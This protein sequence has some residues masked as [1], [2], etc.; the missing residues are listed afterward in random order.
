M[1]YITGTAANHT[2]LWNTLLDFLQNNPALVA[3]G[4]NWTIAWQHATRPN[5]ELVLKGPGTSGTDEVFVGLYRQDEANAIGES[6]IYI[7]GMTGVIPAAERY[8]DHVGVL[9]RRP[10]MFL[11]FSPM[12]YWMVAS[13][14]RFVVVVKISTVYQ[15]LYGGFFLPFGAPSA[16]PYPM[17][18]GGTTGNTAAAGQLVSSWRETAQDSYSQFVYPRVSISNTAT[19]FD[20]QAFLLDPSNQWRVGTINEQQDTSYSLPAFRVG[21]RAYPT[22]LGLSVPQDLL[23]SGFTAGFNTCLGYELL[24]SILA[25]GLN[26]ELPMMPITLHSAANTASPQPVSYGVLDGCFSVGGDTNYAENIVTVGGVDHLV[27]PN[28]MR[29]TSDEYWALALE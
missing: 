14:R 12:Q 25:P 4:Q 22:Y 5:E 6:E 19:F 21:P 2:A 16:Y 10:R 15:A 17:Y 26:G 11:D 18:I 29:T 20:G 23:S 9:P 3:A 28:V 7:A 13:G 27:V 24:R 8:S 1:A